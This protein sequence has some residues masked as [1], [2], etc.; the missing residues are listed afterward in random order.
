MSIYISLSS[1]ELLNN[2][3]DLFKV[4]QFGNYIPILNTF[5]LKIKNNKLIITASD[6]ETTVVSYIKIKNIIK[7]N[8]FSFKDNFSFCISPF[9]LINILKYFNDNIILKIENEKKYININSKKGNYTI[10]FQSSL[11]YPKFYKLKNLTKFFLSKKI[12][13]NAINQVFFLI[14]KNNIRQSINGMLIKLCKNKIIFVS[15]DSYNLIEYSYNICCENNFFEE[16]NNL[17]LIIPRRPIMILKNI[18]LNINDK[19]IIIEYNENNFKILLKNKIFIS[20]II[21]DKFPN[22]KKIIP[23]NKKYIFKINRKE[24]FYSVKRLSLFSDKNIHFIFSKEKINIYTSDNKNNKKAYEYIDYYKNNDILLDK[25]IEFK[26]NYKSFINIIS[27][28]FQKEFYFIFF[29]KNKIIMIIPI[30]KE[31]NDIK[32]KNEKIKILIMPIF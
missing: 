2:F 23:K 1:I 5:L 16:N 17:E 6:L 10:P 19:K 32:E 29:K 4:I 28:I 18:L 9:I 27:H 7:D 31:K 15:T 8:N 20:R 3:K 25:N 12:L 22:Y 13:L 21:N 30:I 26:L 14:N 11:N 24:F